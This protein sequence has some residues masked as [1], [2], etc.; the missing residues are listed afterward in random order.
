MLWLKGHKKGEKTMLDKAVESM[1]K[2]LIRKYTSEFYTNYHF[3]G[4]IEMTSDCYK[5]CF[6]IGFLKAKVSRKG[7]CGKELGY[8]LIPYDFTIQDIR[9]N[10][11]NYFELY[12]NNR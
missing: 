4:E 7:P 12:E 10:E 9:W 1:I 11:F 3:Y 8:L 2:A 5:G 6:H